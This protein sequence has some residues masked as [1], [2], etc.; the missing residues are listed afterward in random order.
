MCLAWFAAASS[1]GLRHELGHAVRGL[2]VENGRVAGVETDRGFIA[3]G[4]VV[5][6]TGAWTNDLLEPLGA[7]AADRA[8]P[9]PGGD[10]AHARRVPPLPSAVVSDA[11]TNVVV[12]PDRGRRSAPSPMP[13]RIRWTRPTTA[14][15][16]LSAGLSDMPFASGLAAALTR[17]GRL[18]R[19]VRGFAGP[20][21]MTPDWNPSSAPA[22]ASRACTWRSAGAATA[23]SSPRRWA[24]WWPPR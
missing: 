4:T 9:A 10:P 2:R 22:P 11:V 15:T 5:L 12:R 17:A 24:R 19:L 1:R 18:R 6:A 3:A 23:S 8:S 13:A 7:R 20:Y 16:A 14:T 21:D